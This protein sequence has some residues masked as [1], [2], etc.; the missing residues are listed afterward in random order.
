VVGGG[1]AGLLAAYYAAPL[2]ESVTVLG[3]AAVEQPVPGSIRHDFPD[4]RLASLAAEAHTL[5]RELQASCGRRLLRTCGHL[6]LARAGVTPGTDAGVPGVAP[7]AGT[8][9]ADGARGYEVL[10]QLGLRREALSG[11]RLASRFPQ[12]VADA[13]WLDVDA[14]LVDVEAVAS[15]LTAAVRQRGVAVHESARVRGL[16]RNRDGWHVGIDYGA[17]GCDSLVITPDQGTNA[18]LELLPDCPARFPPRPGRPAQVTYFTPPRR[19][20]AQFTDLA[21]PSFAYPDAGIYGQPIIDGLTAGVRIGL[22]RRASAGGFGSAADFVAA[23]MPVLRGAPTADAGQE[24]W[25]DSADGESIIGP[26]PGADGVYVAG[27]WDASLWGFAPWIGLV[28]AQLAMDHDTSYDITRFS[29]AR[30]T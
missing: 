7:R 22:F 10:A 14:G 1:I 12:F 3:L 17:L 13:G 26:M 28:L 18:V 23:C 25:V 2:A 9:A 19:A 21:L 15:A 6:T 20:R 16:R 30:F 11:A 27:G 29:P 4:V 24:D 8:D 5:W